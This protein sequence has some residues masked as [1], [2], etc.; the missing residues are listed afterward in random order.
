MRNFDWQVAVFFGCWAMLAI[1]SFSFFRFNKNAVLKRTVLVWG[2]LFADIV[3]LGFMA[4]IGF[5]VQVVF[6][7]I[8]SF[9]IYHGPQL[10][11]NEILPPLWRDTGPCIQSAVLWSVR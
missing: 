9:D 11:R 8:S 7:A 10:L 1:G 3:F 2:H 6:L 4:W 5:P